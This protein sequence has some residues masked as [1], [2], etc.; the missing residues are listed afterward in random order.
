MIQLGHWKE[1]SVAEKDVYASLIHLMNATK[2]YK[3]ESYSKQNVHK[4]WP[5]QLLI[6]C[7]NKTMPTIYATLS[8][9]CV[10][11]VGTYFPELK[12]YIPFLLK[13]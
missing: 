4:S 10:K 12:K 5:A 11:H 13:W 8:V 6:T 3:V 1:A 7:C 9:T 2:L